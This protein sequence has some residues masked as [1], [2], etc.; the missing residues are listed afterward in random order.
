MKLI[1]REYLSLLKESKELDRLLPDLLLMMGIEPIS[2]PQVGVRQYGVDVAAVGNYNYDNTKTLFLFTIKQGDLGRSDWNV[3]E[4]SIR[5]SLDEIKDV[6]LQSYIR[7][8][9]SQLKKKIVLCTGGNLKQEIDLNWT[10]YISRNSIDG[11]LEYEFWGGDKLSILIEEYM[12]NEQIL[13]PEFR[14][15]F[16]K[17]LSLL[18]DPDYDLSDYY[19]IL[20]KVLLSSDFGDLTKPT[21]LNKAKKALKTI[22]LVLNIVFFWA[23]NEQNLKPSIYAAERTI[24][25]AW[26]F[27]RKNDLFQ[28]ESVMKAYRETYGTFVNIYVEYFNK[29]QQY[30]YVK[31]GLH[32]YGRHSI[33]ENM[34]I[35][36]QLGII[37]S[38]GI[39]YVFQAII[40]SNEKLLESAKIISDTA[41]SLIENHLSTRSPY[42]DNHIIEISEAI[43]LLACFSENDF[44][45]QWV[46][47]ILYHIRFAYKNMGQYFPIQ[48]DSFDDIVALTISGTI[49]KE[50]LMEISTLLPI[51]AQWCAVLELKES[52]SLLK[53]IIDNVFKNTTL[54]IWYPDKDTDEFMYKCNAAYESGIIDAPMS[55]PDTIEEMKAM[56]ES[57]KKGTISFEDLSS[58]KYGF[59]TLPIISSRH[60]KMPFLPFYWQQFIPKPTQD[61]QTNPA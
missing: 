35:F 23:K 48:S 21:G 20:N 51:I 54:Q 5:Q 37:C 11:E 9:H 29:L 31:N 41:K 44:L 58:V 6:Y 17:V 3:N 60:Y 27:L 1:I 42:Y 14:S 19:N 39:L 61:C 8:E 40:E 38:I 34:N 32:G 47:D 53:D 24:L 16:R 45:E 36:E 15:L 28:K 30:C 49:N 56:M 2:H 52:Y 43:L 22:H 57:V 25:I 10:G 18:S 7:P 33:I 4:Q 13:Q 46:K 26:E 55:V 59:P 12:L 50:K